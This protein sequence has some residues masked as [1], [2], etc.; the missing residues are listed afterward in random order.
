[1]ANSFLDKTGLTYLWGKIV[2]LVNRKQD[3]LTFDSTPTDNS[4]NPV[5]SGGV[6]AYVDANAGGGGGNS[7]V[8]SGSGTGSV[9]V[10]QYEY[11]SETYT[12]RAIGVGSFAQGA[13]SV[14]SGKYSHAEGHGDYSNK[15]KFTSTTGSQGNLWYVSS[16]ALPNYLRTGCIVCKNPNEDTVFYEVTAINTATKSVKFKNGS[17]VGIELPSSYLNVDLTYF[18]LAA[19]GE[20]SHAEGNSVA[21]GNYSHAEGQYCRALKDYSHA[22]GLGTVTNA[23]FQHATGKFNTE[24]FQG[25]FVVGVGGDPGSR[26]DGFTVDWNG[27][28]VF[29][30]KAT[31][32][33]WYYNINNDDDLITKGYFDAHT[34][35]TV[36]HEEYGSQN[37]QLYP[38]SPAASGEAFE[39]HFLTW[40]DPD[41]YNDAAYHGNDIIQDLCH[42]VLDLTDDNGNETL[43]PLTKVEVFSRT[44]NE[45]QYQFVR[46]VFGNNEKVYVGDGGYGCYLESEYPYPSGE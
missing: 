3:A 30:G 22:E 32:H 29:K 28:G 11:N 2:A 6:K 4:T 39:G 44:V 14:A 46:L 18:Y 37:Y 24:I 9:Q 42:Y 21:I 45:S 13:N 16:T 34:Q 26:V 43:L 33:G 5:T 36:F 27:N 7:P 35:M 40:Y 1:M 19:V 20:G 8:E 10:P 12:Q 41:E 31:S 17:Q 38:A 25:A 15:V 23:L